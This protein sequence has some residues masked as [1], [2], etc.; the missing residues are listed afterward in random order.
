MPHQLHHTSA[1]PLSDYGWDDGYAADFHHHASRGLLPGRVVRVDRGR[2]D[3]VVADG[4]GVTTVLADTAPVATGDPMRVPCTGDW[5]ALDTTSPGGPYVRAVLPRRTSFARST[6]SKRSEA[7][8]LAVNVDHSVVCVSL[9]SAPDLARIE[10]FVSLAW[11]SGSV[12]VVVLTKLDVAPDHAH[13]TA[14][15]RSVA[16]GV[17]VV[18]VSACT[19]T[20]IAELRARL[21]HGTSVL[22]GQSGAGKSTLANA[23]IGRHA[24]T[25][26]GVRD[27]DDKGRHTTTTRELHLLPDGGVLIDTPGL[28][29]VGLWDAGD[30][31]DRAFAE[32]EELTADCRFPDCGH[33][34]EPGCAVLAALADGG[35]PA[36]RWESYLKLRR[37]NERLAARTDARIRAAQRKEWKRRD[38]EARAGLERKRGRLR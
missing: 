22:L 36:R 7:Q 24:M 2:L 6:S 23:L 5:V 1:H 27:R 32:I 8:V 18:P 35:L 13:L 33:R 19:G 30:G 3:A 9:S 29:G 11:A 38:A 4:D 12:P 26:Q 34:S 28:R 10:R 31:I 15:V 25:V 37:E 20:G 21:S 16:P 14:D 17:D